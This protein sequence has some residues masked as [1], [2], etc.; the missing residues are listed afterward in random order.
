[1]SAERV[2][3][4][5]RFT[6]R[7]LDCPICGGNRDDHPGRGIRCG[8][9]LSADSQ[10]AYCTRE[11]RSGALQPG[12]D[13]WTYAHRLHG[14]CGCGE[15]HGQG[16]TV[17]PW[18]PVAA[19]PKRARV[20]SAT[21]WA[22]LPDGGHE[23]ARYAYCG[24]DGDL[25][26]YMVRYDHPDGG[27][28]FM[29]WQ[30][31]G[32]KWAHD[33]QGLTRRLY[34]LP[35]FHKAPR[36]APV[37]IAEGEKCADA[38][39]GL[40]LVATCSPGGAGKWHT[41]PGAREELR[42]RH[43]AILPDHDAPGKRH[44]EDVAADLTGV[45]AS[46]KV[47]ELPG[48]SEHGDVADWIDAGGTRDALLALVDGVPA[49][50]PAEPADSPGNGRDALALA[51]A[52]IARLE[53]REARQDRLDANA[54]VTAPL[55]GAIRTARKWI[56][57]TWHADG[58]TLVRV[59][60][61]DFAARYGVSPQTAGDHLRTLGGYGVIRYHVETTTGEDSLPRSHTS[62][63][64]TELLWHPED[65]HPEVPRNGWGGKRRQTCAKCH[66]D[67]LV[68][69]R[70]MV[71]RACGASTP[72]PDMAVNGPPDESESTPEEQTATTAP[73]QERCPGSQ[74]DCR[75]LDE[76]AQPGLWDTPTAAHAPEGARSRPLICAKDVIDRGPPR[77]CRRVATHADFWH[78]LAPD[79]LGWWCVALTCHV[80]RPSG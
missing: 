4:D 42:G 19:K 61:P 73:A 53:E 2:A 44:A 3:A 50:A 26:Y 23:V 36:D 6:K 63:A 10:W 18:R 79:P 28:S 64:P 1:M 78:D 70:Q 46:I 11:E 35:E 55:K 7:T 38:L 8:G 52:R 48:L 17:V 16:T 41:V 29:P 59:Y 68:I 54:D 31:A 66:S 60:L 39:G 15:T 24:A 49:W 76:G 71:C 77:N 9:Y 14:P 72:L 21:I 32:D 37:F 22:S 13:G 74:D 20:L 69:E 30:P 75:T 56:E 62:I 12:R 67:R 5:Q 80:P 25:V 65:I 47:V 27:K 45:A 57:R 34:R 33:E 40:G 58:E 51:Q 43:V